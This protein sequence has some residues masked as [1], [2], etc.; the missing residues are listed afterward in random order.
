MYT[1]VRNYTTEELISRVVN[2]NSFN[3]FPDEDFLIGVRS[4]ENTPNIYDDKFYHFNKDLKCVNV[5]TGTTNSGAYG[6][7]N[8]FKW[9]SKGAAEIK[10][11]EC[12]YDVWQGGLHKGK[13]KALRQ[14][15]AFKVIRK[16]SYD[17]PSTE[18]E[19][20]S[21]KGLNFHTNSYDRWTKL[22]KW[23]IGGWSTGCQVANEP[24]DYYKS[25]P[26]LLD[27]SRV[28][29]FLLNEF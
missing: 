10:A 21:W 20:E 27:Q 17:D 3:G 14:V 16:K 19:W 8:Y 1:Q 15:G 12:Y 25:L 28:T 26:A 6:F 29:Y 23:I 7:K 5:L 22:R 24:Q 11:D 4:N 9:N 2:L 18:W 13:M